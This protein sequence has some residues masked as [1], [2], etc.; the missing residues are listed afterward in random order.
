MVKR[1]GMLL[2]FIVLLV[3]GLSGCISN[4]SVTST[5]ELPSV[6]DGD[7]SDI[8]T[9]CE[10]Y[11]VEYTLDGETVYTSSD[12]VYDKVAYSDTKWLNPPD[13][14]D[15]KEILDYWVG[16]DYNNYTIDSYEVD[17]LTDDMKRSTLEVRVFVD[18]GYYTFSRLCTATRK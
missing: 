6:E 15:I 1:I 16:E 9:E 11:V 8:V 10:E 5:T 18:E 4:E 12:Y 7:Y 14:E 2:V 3:T 13:D 17:Y